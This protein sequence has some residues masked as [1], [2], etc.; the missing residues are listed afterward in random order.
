MTSKRSGDPWMPAAQYGQSL[1]GMT[2]NLLVT[3]IEDSAQFA[4]TVLGADRVY[5]DVDFAVLR[6]CGSEWM[7]HAD[8][9]Y[10]SSA[11]LGVARSYE[12]RG[13]GVELRLHGCDPDQATAKARASGY[14]VLADAMD[15][16]HGLREAIIIAP[17]GYLWVPD[18][19]LQPA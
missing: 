4:Q 2:V 8:H 12:A 15:K 3:S 14:T 16:P 6:A 18:I 11:M 5:A 13:S 1:T 10:D 9:T 7:L 17:D 19:P